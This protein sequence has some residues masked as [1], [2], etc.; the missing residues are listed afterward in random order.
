MSGSNEYNSGYSDALPRGGFLDKETIL[1]YLSEEDI[2]AFVFGIKPEE[3]Q[4]VCSPFRNDRTPGAYFNIQTIQGRD[5]LMFSDWGD[6]YKIHNDCFDCVQRYYGLPNFYQTLQFIRK[7]LIDGKSIA[8]KVS[9]NDNPTSLEKQ[10]VGLFFSARNFNQLDKLFWERYK[11]S[12]QNLLDDRVFPVSKYMMNNTRVGTFLD[13]AYT[14]CYA[15]TDFESQNKKLYFPYREGKQ[16]FLTTCT[17][18]D[19]GGLRF[20]FSSPQLIITKSYKDYRVIKNMGYNVLWVQSEVQF[21]DSNIINPILEKYE[22]VIIFYDNDETGISMS[23][24]IVES[25][26]QVFPE[27]ARSLNLPVELLSSGIK[28]PSDM[29]FRAGE[30]K[31]RKFLIENINE[32]SR[33]NP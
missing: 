11:I 23:E 15:F 6:S 18:N 19:I 4:Y 17:K 8:K 29:I 32:N 22:D 16:R 25:I 5:K 2:Y 10:R 24:K 13:I 20:L 7:H 31:L 12:K 9:K 3:Y 1:Q 14:P 33:K 26:N 21:P 30:K 28:D 27:K